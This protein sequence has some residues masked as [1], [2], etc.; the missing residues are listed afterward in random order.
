M[1]LAKNFSIVQVSKLQSGRIIN[2]LDTGHN[3]K[4]SAKVF[5]K[6]MNISCSKDNFIEKTK[7]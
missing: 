2:L 7:L 6:S 5:Q 1:N 3:A 4:C